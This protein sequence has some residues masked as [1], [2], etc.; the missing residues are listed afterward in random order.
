METKI[1]LVTPLKDEIDNIE[2]LISAIRSQKL[3]IDT[4]VIVENGST[5]GSK[6]FLSNLSEIDNVS[7]FKVLNFSLKNDRYELGVKYSTVVNEGFKF[8][9]ASNKEFDYV[10]ICD[11]D[12]FPEEDYYESLTHFMATEKID[13][14]SG[15]GVFETGAPDGEAKDWVRG[16]CRL[17][18]WSCFIDSGYLIGPSADTLSLGRAQ[19]KGYTAKPNLNLIYKCREM[20]SRTR[21]SY[22]GFSSYYR[23]ITPAYAILKFFNYIRI[24]Q[25]HQSF[26][27][28]RG[29]FSALISR[30]ERL[31]DI[32]L[33]DYF[34]KTLPRKLGILK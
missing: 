15:V 16:N 29:Y 34:S 19:L 12:C 25:I 31:D 9:L 1:A 26:G 10:G 33:R 6:E 22:Y 4:W 18:R 23:G 11:A 3:E 21:Y 7:N 5:D 30:K 28:L 14:S 27:Y 32:E 20:G 13:I 8:L 2:R 17:W 24:G